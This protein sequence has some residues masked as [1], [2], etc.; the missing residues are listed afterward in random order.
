MIPVYWLI[1]FAV[2]L[3]IEIMTMALTTIWFAGGAFAAFLV[4]LAGAGIEVQLAAFLIVSFLLLFLTRPFA[5]KYINRNTVKTNAEG[6]VG[7]RARVTED[8]NNE[9]ECGTAVIGG[10]EWTARSEDPGKIIPAGTMVEVR[11]IQGV[12]L[13]VKKVSADTADI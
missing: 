2:L 10:Q 5:L 1:G 3:A 9:L 6:L 11:D 4:S 8:I 12:K 7:Q 13:I